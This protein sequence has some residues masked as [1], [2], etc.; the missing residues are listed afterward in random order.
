MAD[1]KQ[2]LLPRLN[3]EILQSETL[4]F[5]VEDSSTDGFTLDLITKYFLTTESLI[6]KIF[7]HPN[8][9]E[10]TLNYVRMFGDYA[11]EPWFASKRKERD[12]EAV[13]EPDFV[14]LFQQVQQMKVSEKIQLALKGNKEARALLLKDSNKQ[15]ILAVLNS[16]RLTEQEVESI[17]QSKNVSED[18]LRVVANNRNWM[19]NYGIIVGLV[20]NPKTP[21]GLS[22]GFI[23]NL[24]PKELNNL[25]KNKGVPE[26]IRSSAGKFLQMKRA[27]K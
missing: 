18:I 3:L 13:Q 17:A 12:A 27:G 20:N 10:A 4:L 19:K 23:K 2:L 26:V 11:Q 14:N 22:L 25:A 21:V 1:R 9:W 24:K 15:V 16:P 7:Q 8:T 6:R 5:L